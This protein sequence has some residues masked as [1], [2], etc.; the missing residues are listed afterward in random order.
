MQG[1]I[2]LIVFSLFIMLNAMHSYSYEKLEN[3][4]FFQPKNSSKTGVITVVITVCSDDIIHVIAAPTDTQLEPTSLIVGEQKGQ[5][6]FFKI[7]ENAPEIQLRT[8]TLL[9]VINED[10]GEISIKDIQNDILLQEGPRQIVP[11]VVLGKKVN[12][13]QQFFQ[14]ADN[15]ALYG[16]GQHQEGI[17][18]W[19]GHYVELVQYNMRAVVPFLLSTKGYGILW[20]N[21]SYTKFYDTRYGS[22]LWSE[23]GD[24][25]NY[26]F[27]YGPEPDA[28]IRNYRGLTGLAPLM[29]KWALGYIQSKERYKTQ[30]EIID[31]AK[32]Y[33]ERQ[34]PLDVIVLDWQYW[35]DG[36]W[37]QKSFNQERFPDPQ[38]MMQ[39]LH[40]ELNM[41][42]M[43]SVWPKMSVRSANYLEM[44]KQEDFLYTGSNSP[45]YDAFNPDAR[46][47]YWKQANEGLF[48]KG[49]DA[50]WCD[51][52]EPELDGWDFNNDAYKIKMKPF[53]GSGARY[54]NAYSLMHAKGMYEN[55][56]LTTEKKR[57]VNLTRSAFAGQ[58]KYS[59]ITWSGDIVATWDVFKNQI[60]A[61]LNFC[62]SGLPYWTTDI[63]G[64]FV[65][66]SQAGELGRGE[67]FRNGGYDG[68]IED[69][70]YKE[71]YVRWFQYGAFCPIFRSHGTDISREIWRFG[72][73]GFW[74]FDALLKFDNLRYRLMPYIYSTAWK[75][76][77]DGYTI[78]RGLMMDFRHDFHV[79][80]IDDQYMFGP[81]MMINPVTKPKASFRKV[82]LPHDSDWYNFWT[83][84]KY[85][86]GQTLHVPTPIDEIPLFVK[87]GS[88]IPMGPF[89]QYAAES[90]D[91]LELRIYRGADGQFTLYEDEDDSY[92]YER[93]IFS[94]IEFK[95][96]DKNQKLIIEN[97]TGEF[98]GM[99]HNRSFHIVLVNNNQGNGVDL[100]TKP[101]KMIQYEGKKKIIV[102]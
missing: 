88:I 4:V 53:I 32:E 29:P 49:I 48:S 26:F 17:F 2:Y 64:F 79:F 41:H 102:F 73:P 19:R 55:Q 66:S 7:E 85:S 56:R 6:P 45:F 91:P 22:F 36:L 12:H 97:R 80:E 28:V 82:Y 89:I 15:E 95:W 14:W 74:A 44:A 31:I 62:M 81:A 98:P 23:V 39:T 61:G 43:I 77:S 5:Q 86:G 46:A 99:L 83:G 1:K 24:A 18:N 42:L 76:T 58:Q 63:G 59:T 20:D 33:R 75:V 13:V 25:V 90:V 94:T 8:K 10:N 96:D 47:L 52:T 27:I 78:M 38:S 72:D 37:G 65:Q 100:T 50:W 34:I 11:S 16:L 101:D 92:N 9:I 70:D 69:D 71:L 84:K 21:Y 35:D 54:M 93:G 67:W 51:A 3:G 87:E 57:V 40:S 30:Q 68:G 60:P